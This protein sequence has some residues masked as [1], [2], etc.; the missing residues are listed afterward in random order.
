VS[1]TG[2]RVLLIVALSSGAARADL[3]GARKH[4]ERAMAAFALERFDVAAEEYEAAFEQ[5]P[6]PEL[7]YNAAQSY[8]LAGKK[9]RAIRLYQ[10]YL[11]VFSAQVRNRDEIEQHIANLQKAI[12]SE[13][14]ASNALPNVPVPMEPSGNREPLP[15]KKATPTPVVTKPAPPPKPV[16]VAV[17]TQPEKP[18][19]KP[20]PVVVAPKPEPAVVAPAPEPVVVAPPPDDKVD[21]TA[22]RPLVKRPL[23]WA[24]T[25]GAVV[26]VAVAV[27]LAVV[28]GSSTHYPSPSLGSFQEN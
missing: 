4:N 7:L 11:R 5:K 26:V 19:P 28:L 25:G 1:R 20:E 8:R 2:L 17:K 22:P 15:P 6:L 13:K 14:T 16:A 21:L 3:A 10:S 23:F 9:E 27:V 18:K 24:I 12:D